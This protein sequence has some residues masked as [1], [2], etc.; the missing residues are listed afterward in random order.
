MCWKWKPPAGYRS[1]FGAEQVNTLASMVAR[2]YDAPHEMV[3]V[4]DDPKGI[5]PAIRVIPLW[6]DHAKVPSPWGFRNPSCY[7]RLKVFSHEARELIGP[8]FVSLDLDVV[9]TGDMRP[10]WDRPEDFVIWG[11]TAKGTPYNGGMFLLRAGTRPQVWEKFDPVRSP[12]LG[13][14]HG[15]V[16]SDQ[17]WIATCLGSKEPKWS[18]ADGVYSYRNEIAPNGGKLPEDARIVLLHGRHDPWDADILAKHAWVR[19]H[20]R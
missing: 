17:A 11:D 6:R 18:K 7:R 19:E 16:G 9:I 14:R 13:K 1:H 10:I 12:M 15:Y 20:Y 2:H 5:D 8:R 3:C 4:T